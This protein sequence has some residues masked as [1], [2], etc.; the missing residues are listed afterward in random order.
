MA[1][2]FTITSHYYYDRLTERGRK[3]T[4]AVCSG[5]SDTAGLKEPIGLFAHDQQI[6]FFAGIF[7]GLN[8][9]LM[10]VKLH[11]FAVYL[12]CKLI[13]QKL[14]IMAR[15]VGQVDR[16]SS[17]KRKRSSQVKP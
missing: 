3:G 13:V 8:N 16:A 5:W 10:S 9:V 6:D 1:S 17:L 11:V 15:L 7:D 12:Q 4:R 14:Q 2:Y